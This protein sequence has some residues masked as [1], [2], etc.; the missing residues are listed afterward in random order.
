M[1][2]GIVA[3]D[4]RGA[5]TVDRQEYASQC[6][7]ERKL[8]PIPLERFGFRV[9]QGQCAAQMSVC[10]AVSAAQLVGAAGVAQV[11]DGA[12]RVA[13]VVEVHRELRRNLG[14]AITPGRFLALGDAAMEF[15]APNPEVSSEVLVSDSAVTARA[16]PS[17]L[18]ASPNGSPGMVR[19][20]VLWGEF[21]SSPA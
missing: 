14:R 9:Q 6:D 3:F 12:T 18:C 4:F 17:S 20:R 1:R 19:L 13:S 10:S 15:D 16:E 7:T 2:T 21:G 5:K 11:D 8:A